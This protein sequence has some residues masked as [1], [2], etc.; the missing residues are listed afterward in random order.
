MVQP[1]PGRLCPLTSSCLSSQSSYAQVWTHLHSALHLR[2]P[3][4]GLHALSPSI[5]CKLLRTGTF[6]W[7]LTHHPSTHQCPGGATY[8]RSI[9]NA[10]SS[11]IGSLLQLLATHAHPDPWAQARS[12]S[13]FL[14]NTQVPHPRHLLA[15][16]PSGPRVS[17]GSSATLRPLG[18]IL[19]SGTRDSDLALS[20]R[21]EE[22]SVRVWGGARPQGRG[23]P[24]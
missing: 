12:P 8:R 4:G 15:H 20:E 2:P 14:E 10:R 9:I 7:L 13:I 24:R 17:S 18:T 3:Y 11:S 16:E 5:C 6:P 19:S 23:R 1:S 21:V 22:V